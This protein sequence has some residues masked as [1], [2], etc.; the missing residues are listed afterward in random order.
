MLY[1]LRGAFFVSAIVLLVTLTQPISVVAVL[2]LLSLL[3]LNI[4]KEKY[5]LVA[6]ISGAEV[7]LLLGFVHV[8]PVF[9]LFSGVVAFDV[10][11]LKTHYALIPLL[12]SVFLWVSLPEIVVLLL[13]LTICSFFGYFLKYY[14]QQLA[15]LMTNY[16]QERKQR[17]DLE[18]V[19]TSLLRSGA[20][21]AH[22]AELKERNRIAHQIHDNLGHALSSIYMQLQAVERIFSVDHAKAKCLLS[23]SIIRLSSAL[24]LLRNTVHNLQSREKLGLDYIKEVIAHFTYC[25]VEFS[26]YGDWQI[27]SASNLELISTIIKEAFT[28]AAKHSKA[29]KIVVKIEITEGYLRLY[30]SDNGIGCKTVREGMGLY[31]MRERVRSVNGHLSISSQDGF[32]IVCFL[33]F[34]SG[35][36]ADAGIVSR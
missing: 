34:Q 6:W 24:D 7:V 23:Q 10:M 32:I 8:N 1:L 13:F 25:P 4:Y 26:A 36:D 33:P 19:K 20:E 9:W 21:Q 15:Q 27:V 16:D 12:V 18:N 35:V 11:R 3:A 5:G 29:T 14:D 31:G 17:Y 30:I 22:L 28:N 2:G